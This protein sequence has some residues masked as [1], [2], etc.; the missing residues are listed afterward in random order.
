M[1]WDGLKEGFDIAYNAIVEECERYE[2]A[3]ADKVDT[4]EYY[5]YLTGLDRALEVLNNYEL[6]PINGKEIE[7]E[8]WAELKMEDMRA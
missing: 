6:E 7:E 2:K 3:N 5:D 8:R 1:S 4:P